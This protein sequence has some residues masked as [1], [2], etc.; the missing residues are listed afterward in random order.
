M[1]PAGLVCSAFQSTGGV[2][3]PGDPQFGNA[4]GY[5][6]VW[7]EF[8]PLSEVREALPMLAEQGLAINLGWPVSE[9]WSLERWDLV[10]EAEHHGVEVRPWL[11]LGDEQGYWPNSENAEL[12]AAVADYLL[13]AWDAMGLEPTQLVVD[14]EMPLAR[15]LEYSELVADFN[16]VGAI[17]LLKEGVDREQYANATE[18]YA[19]LVDDAH[20]RGWEVLVATVPQ[21]L[22]DYID[23]DD[24]LRQEFQV[25][26][27]GIDWDVVSVIAY[28]SLA[29]DYLGTLPSPFFVYTY[30]VHARQVFGPR[31]GL[32][33]GMTDPGDITAGAPSYPSG[34]QLR[35]DAEAAHAAGIDGANVAVYN[36][37]GM[38]RREPT[39]QW[40]QAPAELEKPPKP[41]LTSVIAREIA[42]ATDL[43][44]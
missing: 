2:C 4:V 6:A 27:A 32:S 35:E 10:R 40:L 11:L 9:M 36:L 21:V 38:V 44:L 34:D 39:E 25:P 29:E 28:R 37:R 13:T 14:M 22:D 42:F 17:A 3:D 31:A 15:S 33:V 20:E 12:F 5:G 30:G 7:S 19:A 1:L 18:I 16:V 41:D 8:T 23:G 24:G 43:F 26:L